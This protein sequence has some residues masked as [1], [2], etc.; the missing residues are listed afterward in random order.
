MR[1]LK[2][3]R[4]A[5][6][7]IVAILIVPLLVCT[8]L[9][10][11][12]G[13]AYARNRE[14]Q[15]AADA[16]A[17]AVAQDCAGGACGNYSS[18]ATTFATANVPSGPVSTAAS[19]N[20]STGKVTVNTTSTVPFS[21]G[22]VVG[23]DSTDV[24]ATATATWGSPSAGTAL[25]P[26]AFSWCAF[27]AQTGGGVPTGTTQST[28]MLPKTD[29]TACTSISG[30]PVPGGFAW[31]DS[32]TCSTQTTAG[33]T[34]LSDPG[35]SPTGTGCTADY[36]AKLQNK[37]VILPIYDKFGGTG[38][39][40]WYRIY[41]YVAFRLTGYNFGGQYKWNAPCTGN[42]SC[43]RGYFTQILAPSDAFTYGAG[44]PDLGVR[45]VTLT[46]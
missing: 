28:I 24:H 17:L 4:G 26:L 38:S 31:L 30:N 11:D 19:V 41:S 15:N 22:P 37:T 32:D 5:V 12:M 13:S 20:T 6:A 10:V 44:T 45:L 46:N 36:I 43:I 39:S 29:G 3:E 27:A 9:V 23:I 42:D 14:A 1:S 16:A 34:A 2:N 21:F 7:V 8:A 33:G 25:L 18:T 40:A 35:R